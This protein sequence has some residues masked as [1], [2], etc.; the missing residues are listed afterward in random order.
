MGRWSFGEAQARPTTADPL[1]SRGDSDAIGRRFG[2]AHRWLLAMLPN[3]EEVVLPG[4]T[5]LPQMQDPQ[6]TAAAITS[7]WSR[8]PI[9]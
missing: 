9:A 2:D 7:F 8:H 3:A 1:D 4:M 5:H 6:A